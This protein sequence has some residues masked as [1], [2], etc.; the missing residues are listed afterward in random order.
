MIDSKMKKKD[1]VRHNGNKIIN[2]LIIIVL[3]IM[4]QIPAAMSIIAL[5]FSLKINDWY[6]IALS[7]LILGLAL[8]I[9]WA[10]RSYYLYRTYENQCHKMSMKDVFKNIGFFFLAIICSIT[11]NALMFI[12][13]GDSDTKNEKVIDESL[14]SLMDKSHL[15]HLSIVLV[16]IICLCFIGP[17]LE[18]LVFR[19]IF[20]ETLFMKSRFWLPLIISSVTFS[21]L[22][23]STNIFSFGLYFLMGCVLYVAYDIRRN[24]K[25]SMMVHMLNNSI[26]TIP[27][28]LAYLYIYFK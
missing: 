5:P 24:I 13:I 28:F 17:Y 23:L 26:T 21:S 6:T 10:I 3:T 9:V 19:G 8:F 20:K 16:T 11:S 7:M 27:L 4:I 14:D 18:E 25:D 22:H 2:I 1:D 15:P 12:F